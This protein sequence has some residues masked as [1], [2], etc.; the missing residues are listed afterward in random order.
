MRR[1]TNKQLDYERYQRNF[2]EYTTYVPISS[3]DVPNIQ[4][5]PMYTL[6]NQYFLEVHCNDWK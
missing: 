2:K 6:K 5:L 4:Y 3:T 1:G